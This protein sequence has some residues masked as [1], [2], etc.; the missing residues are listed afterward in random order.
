MTAFA[1]LLLA[2]LAPLVL[3]GEAA[4]DLPTPQEVECLHLVNRFRADPAGEGRRLMRGG[5]V[6]YPEAPFGIDL[7]LCRAELAELKPVA[8][9][10]MDLH[11][12]AS[13]RGHAAWMIANDQCAHVQAPGTPGFTGADPL[14][15]MAA[16]GFAGFAVGENCYAGSLTP[17]QAV[18]GYVIDW[19]AGDGQLIAGRPH[20][21]M[22]LS[23]AVDLAGTAMVPRTGGFSS[24]QNFGRGR[25]GR[26][27]G[28]VVYADRNRNGRFDAGEG[29]GGVAVR[30]LAVATTTWPSGGWALEL[31]SGEAGEL[32]FELAGQRETVAIE[33]GRTALVADWPMPLPDDARL[34][35]RLEAAAKVAGPAGRI[36]RI[37]AATA[38]DRLVSP[39]ARVQALAALCAEERNALA[40]DQERIRD[41]VWWDERDAALAA[42]TASTGR[43]QGS[44][45]AAWFSGAGEFAKVHAKAVAYMAQ[46]QTGRPTIG[47]VRPALRREIAQLRQRLT[48]VEWQEACDRIEDVLATI[49]QRRL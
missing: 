27:A 28:G 4:A 8:P 32:A 33:A 21:R 17:R 3:S 11:L 29:V 40:A 47:T 24:A 38:L 46:M 43:W 44:D 36:G 25:T 41:A 5:W 30:G 42:I 18:V 35:D 45:A 39:R 34:L 9:L 15:R 49:Q 26:P 16:S 2:V 6:G 31:P 1:V 12:L 22:L 14:A 48:C 37:N 19:G 10:V 20:R 23:A 13:A 7:R